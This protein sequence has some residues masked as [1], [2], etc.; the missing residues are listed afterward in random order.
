[1]NTIFSKEPVTNIPT[2]KSYIISYPHILAYFQNKESYHEGD[3]VCGAHVV[4]G[5]MPTI[6]HIY[7]KNKPLNL[8]GAARLLTQVK[9]GHTLNNNEIELIM[10]MINNSLVGTSK[11]L[12]FIAPERYAIWDSKICG[13]YLK[14]KPNQ[15][16]INNAS[17]YQNYLYQLLNLQ[18]DLRF[19]AF[20]ESVNKKLGYQVSCIGALELILFLN[21]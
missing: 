17:T 13:Y 16:Q 5:W 4:Y 1:M 7:L 8:A 19:P 21:S 14:K 12:H 9:Q 11:L 3:I 2:D 6:L 20:H 15:N 18:K 10:G